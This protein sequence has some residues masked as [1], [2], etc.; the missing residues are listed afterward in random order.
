MIFNR[1][2]SFYRGRS[3]V[4]SDIYLFEAEFSRNIVDH[5]K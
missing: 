1:A 4:F 2:E 3:D 5:R